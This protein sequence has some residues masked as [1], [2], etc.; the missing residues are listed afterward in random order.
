MSTPKL[1]QIWR[2]PLKSGAP[3]SLQTADVGLEGLIQ[4]RRL[5]MIDANGQM[6]TGR[7]E[8]KMLRFKAGIANQQLSLSHPDH[9]QISASLEDLQISVP[10]Q[11]WS[12]SFEAFHISDEVDA[13]VSRVLGQAA[14]L[15]YCGERS[16]R[17]GGKTGQSLSMADGYP[18]LLI[19][20]ASLRELNWR[21]P[22]PLSMERFR[23]NLVVSAQLPFIEDHWQRVR[24]GEV[25]FEL[26]EPC[27]RCNFT[28]LDP[29]TLTYQAEQEPLTT[30]SKFRQ[31]EDG[32][33]YFGQ[34][35]I[36]L[37]TGVITQGDVVEVLQTRQPQAYPDKR[38]VSPPPIATPPAKAEKLQFELNG[39]KVTGDNQTSLL[40]QGLSAGVELS[41][42]C[43]SGRCSSCMMQLESG[44]VIQPPARA[45]NQKDQESG[46]ILACCAIPISDIR[47]HSLK[48]TKTRKEPR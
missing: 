35:L 24:I 14:Q 44:E 13:Y 12:D 48:P 26:V 43:R 42:R 10:A 21:S 37:N 36:A 3:E 27:S 18:L 47:A 25:E 28:T 41:Y 31:G 16:Q 39:Q 33:L 46:K 6:I 22:E 32:Q 20:D 40:A 2:Y 45:L 1:S 9:E 38:D 5:L 15:L 7:S 19:S 23:P 11:V 30:L 8:P 4:D 29:E 17:L 34:N